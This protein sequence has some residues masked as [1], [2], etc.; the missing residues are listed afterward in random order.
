MNAKT[1]TANSA[2]AVIAPTHCAAVENT[3]AATSR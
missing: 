1:P 3:T 2:I